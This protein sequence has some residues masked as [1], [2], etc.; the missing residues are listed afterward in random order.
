MACGDVPM[1][2]LVES[3]EKLAYAWNVE[4]WCGHNAG[5]MRTLWWRELQRLVFLGLCSTN[6][7]VFCFLEF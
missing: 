7:L 3:A 5:T 2:D 1:P 6:F 4:L